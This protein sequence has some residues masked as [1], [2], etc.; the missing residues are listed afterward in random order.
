MTLD[1]TSRA[2]DEMTA[3]GC[4]GNNEMIDKAAAKLKSDG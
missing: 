3:K 4:N 1:Y 2:P